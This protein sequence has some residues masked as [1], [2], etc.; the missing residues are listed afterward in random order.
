MKKLLFVVVALVVAGVT[1]FFLKQCYEKVQ[2]VVDAE[3]DSMEEGGLL[4]PATLSD[5]DIYFRPDTVLP[6]SP[7]INDMVDFAN[8][9]AILR[10]AY[11]DAELW[12]LFGTVVNNE[13]SH[14][15]TDIIKDADTRL[16]AEQ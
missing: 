5:K 9:E 16:A 15:K 12:F 4:T 11:C 1:V 8:G 3:E 7:V 10:A 13:I 6:D 2:Q 14:L